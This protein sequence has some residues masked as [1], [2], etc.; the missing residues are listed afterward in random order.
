MNA[1]SSA[2]STSTP[3]SLSKMERSSWVWKAKVA[4]VC[5]C[6]INKMFSI[7][8]SNGV[9]SEKWA[10]IILH[11]IDKIIIQKNATVSTQL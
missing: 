11:V 1:G 9:I 7:A 5:S 6:P 2:G 8:E 10:K 3:A 4:F